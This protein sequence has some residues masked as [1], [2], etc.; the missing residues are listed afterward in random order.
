MKVVYT[1][2]YGNYDRLEDPAVVNND[3]DYICFTD[4]PNLKSKVYEIIHLPSTFKDSAYMARKV[5]LQ[6]HEFLPD[7]EINVWHDCSM[8]MLVDPDKLVADHV[9]KDF[10]IMDHPFHWCAYKESKLCIKIG[11]DDTKIMYNQTQRYLKDKMPENLGLVA[12]GVQVRRNTKLNI[13]FLNAWWK[14][15]E[16]GS[17]RDQLSFNYVAWKMNFRYHKMPW[18]ICKGN[19]LAL[20]GHLKR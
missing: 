15:V 14:E 4:N 3:W 1:A 11:K 13:K 20:G 2:N 19:Y 6:P 17:K 5:K 12:S 9:K 10:N 7:H 8:R 18:R 16:N